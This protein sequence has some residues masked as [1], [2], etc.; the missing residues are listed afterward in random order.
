MTETTLLNDIKSI[1]GAHITNFT[2]DIIARKSETASSMSVTLAIV[3]QDGS[4]SE[5]LIRELIDYK[6]QQDY[7]SVDFETK[8]DIGDLSVEVILVYAEIYYA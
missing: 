6:I 5:Q 3:S 8:K 1:I 4:I 2:A 7:N